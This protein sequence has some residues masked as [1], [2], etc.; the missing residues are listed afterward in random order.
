MA[1]SPDAAPSLDHRT[2]VDLAGPLRVDSRY[3]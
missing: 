1:L 2:P 3:V